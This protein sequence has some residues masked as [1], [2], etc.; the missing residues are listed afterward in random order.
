M[1][2]RAP[3]DPKA[4][5]GVLAW[6]DTVERLDTLLMEIRHLQ[7]SIIFYLR[8]PIFYS[9]LEY[10]EDY[11]WG[12]YKTSTP[13][14]AGASAPTDNDFVSQSW[15]TVFRQLSGRR[16]PFKEL[17]R[18]WVIRPQDSYNASPTIESFYIANERA[19]IKKQADDRLVQI[20]GSGLWNSDTRRHYLIF[21]IL[22]KI[23]SI[24]VYDK[25]HLCL[26]GFLA[27]RSYID[28]FAVDSRSTSLFEFMVKRSAVVMRLNHFVERFGDLQAQFDTAL[29][30]S[31]QEDPP[32]MLLRR[33]EQG[34]YTSFMALRSGEV[35][36][37]IRE[38]LN[39]L[40]P[41]QDPMPARF[42]MHRWRH[43]FTSSTQRLDDDLSEPLSEET[44][45]ADTQFLNS[46][47]WM[48]D[49]PDLLPIL[50][51]EIAHQDILRS[52][53][54]FWSPQLDSR[55]D[56]FSRLI[57]LLHHC[58]E[59]F[60]VSA[61]DRSHNPLDRPQYA[62]LEIGSDLIAA[63]VEGHAYLYALFLEL[64]SDHLG[65][66]LEVPGDA[67][68]LELSPGYNTTVDINW[69]SRSWYFR[70]KLVC[71]WLRVI[72]HHKEGILIQRL[73]DGIEHIADGLLEYLASLSPVDSEAAWRFWRGL[74]ERLCR[75][76]RDSDAAHRVKNW[77]KDRSQNGPLGTFRHQTHAKHYPPRYYDPLDSIVRNFL[78]NTF[79]N[80]K[81]GDGRLL[82]SFANIDLNKLKEK[83]CNFYLDSFP[84]S[85]P[86]D[87][88]NIS[89][90]SLRFRHLQDIPWEC[91]LHSALDF[92]HHKSRVQQDGLEWLDLFHGQSGMGRELYKI[93]L[94][95]NYQKIRPVN[96]RL[97]IAVRV[98]KRIL[99]DAGAENEILNSLKEWVGTA[100]DGNIV[101]EQINAIHANL[102]NQGFAL[103][104]GSG[105]DYCASFLLTAH[106]TSFRDAAHQGL[107]NDRTRALYRAF[108]EKRQGHKLEQLYKRLKPGED[109]SSLPS[110]LRD[111]LTYLELWRSQPLPDCP[112][113][114]S[115]AQTTELLCKS[116]SVYQQTPAV[117][118]YDLARVTFIN[119]NDRHHTIVKYLADE[120]CI[121][122]GG[123]IAQKVLGRFDVLCL[124]ET[125]PMERTGIGLVGRPCVHNLPFLVRRETGIA[126]RL[127][128]QADW[129]VVGRNDPKIIGFLSILL[130]QRGSRLSFLARVIHAITY[131]AR[132]STKDS[133]ECLNDVASLF[134]ERD[135]AFI[136]EGWGD[137]IIVFAGESCERLGDIFRI[138]DAIYHDFLV[139]RTELV[140]TPDCLAAAQKLSSKYSI[141]MYFRLRPDSEMRFANHSFVRGMQDALKGHDL[142]LYKTPGRSDFS[143]DASDLGG[144]F[145]DGLTL[146]M[147]R[148]HENR[149]HTEIDDI[150]TIIGQSFGS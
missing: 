109:R 146:F 32:P 98:V 82:H 19:S 48:P 30:L 110:R 142:K 125:R 144:M 53:D 36:Q 6:L 113:G 105:P 111:L 34:F 99:S 74:S 122:S 84:L 22:Q 5:M 45:V 9:L 50:A 61:A 87:F 25:L 26:S 78:F 23:K 16:P 136:C 141:N 18:A 14:H 90:E 38:L 115:R 75:L 95:F 28:K 24:I 123:Y 54:R 145:E 17:A 47:Y 20:G 88:I 97:A 58:F 56:S 55:D 120:D 127:N 40:S 39:T 129:P 91:C 119:S 41:R 63:A 10:E 131:C 135:F 96:D 132:H 1:K 85:P 71:A 35:Y 33:Q 13:T 77:R 66:I 101:V 94:E 143:F 65:G 118:N 27:F 126:C 150:I 68:D 83:F 11:L 31:F 139:E 62:L 64:T 133:G 116:F 81:K 42:V 79:V 108:I 112:G 72:H 80:L 130:S 69:I 3:I 59:S 76:V 149:I 128:L 100:S 121:Y 2:D 137:L 140:L 103:S 7:S 60:G 51:H 15:F 89:D 57:K 70:L 107:A 124:K 52:Y 12:R 148:L 106:P 44:T 4:I 67:F 92:V 114:F 117:R 46:S 104:D 21:R 37:A 134:G 138:Q 29:D 102:Q 86:K 73:L 147:K 8:E 49:R 43:D 93:G